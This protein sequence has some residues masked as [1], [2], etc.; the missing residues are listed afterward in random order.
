MSALSIVVLYERLCKGVP[1]RIPAMSVAEFADFLNV[2]AY[3]KESLR[4]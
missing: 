3:V 2:L 4:V 1:A